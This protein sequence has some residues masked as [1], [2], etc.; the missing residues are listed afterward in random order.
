[1]RNTL[2]TKLGDLGE[3]RILHEIIPKYVS[4]AGDDCAVLGQHNG[5][6]VIT[7]VLICIEN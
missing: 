3:R 5:T 7:T 2:D 1:M 6:L 4:A